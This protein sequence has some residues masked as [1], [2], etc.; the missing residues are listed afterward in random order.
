MGLSVREILNIEYDDEFDVTVYTVNHPSVS[1][2]V[3]EVYK[4]AGEWYARFQTKVGKYR[5]LKGLG[6]Y[7]VID[8]DDEKDH[9]EVYLLDDWLE[10]ILS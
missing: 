7:L 3:M 10:K 8:R 5:N 9:N 6:K 4:F 1:N 2:L